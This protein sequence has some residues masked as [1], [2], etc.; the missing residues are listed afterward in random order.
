MNR[1]RNLIGVTRSEWLAGVGVTALT[2]SVGCWIWT[3]P[4]LSTVTRGRAPFVLLLG[5][6]G[7]ACLGL[8]MV[9]GRRRPSDRHPAVQQATGWSWSSVPTSSSNGRAANQ[10]GFRVTGVQS[11][12][13][14]RPAVDP[15]P[16]SG[17]SE[18]PARFIAPP[19]AQA[20][21]FD[22]EFT[23]IDDDDDETPATAASVPVVPV[24]PAADRP[25]VSTRQRARRLTA[26]E[27]IVDREQA[28]PGGRP[29][30]S[31]RQANDAPSRAPQ[32]PRRRQADPAADDV[33][34]PTPRPLPVDE[35]DVL[36]RRIVDRPGGPRPIA[37]SV[38]TADEGRRA[39]AGLPPQVRR[40]DGEDGDDAEGT[41]TPV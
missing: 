4:D 27:P 20:R 29:G 8:S 19:T 21:S 35:L 13:R 30:R 34:R 41:T 16:R 23:F 5:F 36:A 37:R 39:L 6:V 3:T 14:P 10:I 31:V 28:P 18:R 11:L 24:V 1:R 12:D 17:A 22:D 26:T 40:R 2:A 32:P 15:R 7:L 25:D 38:R 33:L 9:V